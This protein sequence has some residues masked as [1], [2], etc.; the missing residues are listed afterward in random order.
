MVTSTSLEGSIPEPAQR[1]AFGELILPFSF[2]A[3]VSQAPH[4]SVLACKIL[5][6]AGVF[7]IKGITNIVVGLYYIF[8]P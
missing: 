4:K 6:D 2:Y 8:L 3:A 7:L 1:V 5:S